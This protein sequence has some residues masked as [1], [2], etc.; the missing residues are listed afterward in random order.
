VRPRAS[1]REEDLKALARKIAAKTRPRFISIPRERGGGKV[2]YT[3]EQLTAMHRGLTVEQYRLKTIRKWG[4]VDRPLQSVWPRTGRDR[5]SRR[6]LNRLLDL[7]SWA[8]DGTERWVRLN[9]EDLRA[10][11]ELRHK[12]SR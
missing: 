6:A 1:T 8:A 11:H 10:L 4:R 9:E 3:E 5:Q 12:G 7:Q 2:H